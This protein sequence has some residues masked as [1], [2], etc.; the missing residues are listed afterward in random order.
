MII[1]V[2]TWMEDRGWGKDKREIAAGIRMGGADGEKRG[3]ERKGDGRNV[4]GNK[5]G[6][7]RRRI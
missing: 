3:E 6:I 5:K 1:L 2:E 7:V 4:N